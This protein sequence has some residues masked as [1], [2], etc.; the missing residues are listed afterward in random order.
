MQARAFFERGH[1]LVAVR[2]CLCLYVGR[3]S[4][5]VG[6]DMIPE[7]VTCIHLDWLGL[8]ELVCGANPPCELRR[9]AISR[10]RTFKTLTIAGGYLQT[11]AKN[12][13]VLGRRAASPGY[14]CHH[15]EFSAPF[16]AKSTRVW[17]GLTPATSPNAPYHGE[18]PTSLWTW[19]SNPGKASEG[20]EESTP[21]TS[22][23]TTPLSCLLFSRPTPPLSR[24]PRPPEPVDPE[25][26]L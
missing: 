8:T 19:T 10:R 7:V 21:Q 4:F 18:V 6:G 25:T 11:D 26:D 14:A 12:H 5:V 2:I 1:W 16:P 15:R 13:P 23:V 24:S 20:P 3:F 22:L 9:S 17:R